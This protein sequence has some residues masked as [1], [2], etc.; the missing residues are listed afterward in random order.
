MG[1]A[2]I[3]AVRSARVAALAAAV[4]IGSAVVPARPAAQEPRFRGG[5]NLVRL[6][7]YASHDGVAV[8]DLTAADFEVL[9][10]NVPQQ[11]TAF[12][13]MRA[14]ETT[15]D[16]ARTEPA[17]VMDMRARAAEPGARVFVLFLDT[18]H[19]QL[20]GSYRAANPTA[21]MLDR[22]VG[23]DDL[24]GIMT[25][26]MS[27]RNMTLSPRTAP[28]GELL[29]TSWAWGERGRTGGGDR[30]EEDL[31]ACYPDRDRT[32]GLAEDVIAKRREQQ[33]LRALLDLVDHLEEAREERTFVLLLTEG[34][35]LQPADEQLARPIGRTADTP[36][37]TGLDPVGV[38]PTGR[39]GTPAGQSGGVTAW[40]ERERS[41]VALSDLALEFR[42]LM[43]RANR[44]NV[45]FYPI[46]ARGLAAVDDPAAATGT[47]P[48]S[49]A[50]DAARLAA[51]QAS[52][53]DLAGETDGAVVLNTA[54]D[55]AL[56]RLLTDVGSYYLLGYVSSNPKLD[57]RYRRI[58][59]RVKRPGVAVRARSG[60][61]APFQSDAAARTT[62]ARAAA[63]A[64]SSSSSSSSSS[65]STGAGGSGSS[66]SSSVADAL[67]RLP[68]TRRPP[69]LH[70]IAA[71]GRGVVNVVVELDRVTANAPEWA[72]G[73]AL[74]VDL[75]PADGSAGRRR[76]HSE[77]I[78]PGARVHAVT[79]PDGELLRAGRYQV[80][81]QATPE[82]GRTPVIVTATADVP[83]TTALVGSGVIASRRGPST[84]R[85]Y[86]PTADPRFR[87]TERLTLELAKLA[88]DT[89]VSGRMLNRGNQ[90]LQIPVTISERVDEPTGLRTIVAEVVLAPLAAGEYVLE[91]TATKG[92]QTETRTFAIRVVP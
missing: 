77:A 62:S 54:L 89:V 56:P 61:L 73:G 18:P 9:E 24:V 4:L 82:G 39:L 69:P 40:C 44:A 8:T 74:V 53:R 52:L 13:V 25:P 20:S 35:Q 26:D 49:L 32:A 12:E 51:R 90:V 19:V 29:R 17:N 16:T 70:L 23:A 43:Q 50:A 63:P 47:R 2:V 14:R 22:V 81:V 10:D 84:G 7:V 88:D 80:R 92:T 59:V 68:M 33:T 64:V 65:F 11:V 60:Y 42:Q 27:A 37:A 79:V 36:A 30:R 91:L 75:E 78:A 41:L 57:G 48:H 1:G 46:D 6:D 67:S 55:Q 86:E 31:R 87:R 66:S 15:P 83:G 21:Q 28:I 45:S 3:S 58:T 34:W 38:A 71:G 85:S 76:S 5:T 72:K